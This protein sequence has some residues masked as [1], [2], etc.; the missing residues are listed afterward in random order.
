MIVSWLGFDL[1]LSNLGNFCDLFLLVDLIALNSFNKITSKESTWA[2][3]T[4]VGMKWCTIVGDLHR[5]C[6]TSDPE[7]LQ[8][9]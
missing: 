2:S 7:R 9:C 5:K 3:S 4:V 6:L 1:S 8:L